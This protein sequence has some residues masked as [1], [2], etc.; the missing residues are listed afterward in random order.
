MKLGDRIVSTPRA[1]V[2]A[3]MMIQGA[4]LLTASKLDYQSGAYD[5]VFRMM[6][7]ELWGIA[8]FGVGMALWLKRHLITLGLSCLVMMS[9]AMGSMYAYW[10]GHEGTARTAGL[11]WIIV[12]LLT[13]WSAGRP[14]GVR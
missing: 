9:W 2:A 12:S 3:G 6:P 5:I 14:G 11:P 7:R 13:L 8:F 1:F 10:V 4:G